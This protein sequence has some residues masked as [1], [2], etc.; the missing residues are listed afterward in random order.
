MEKVNDSHPIRI[1][2]KNE[3]AMIGPVQ[4]AARNYAGILGFKNK[5]CFHIE[6]LLEEIL[7]N[8][9]KFDFMPGQRE[10]INISFEKST[11]GM[12][13]TVHSLSVPLD[14]ERINS[15]RQT[16][17]GSILE[18][19]SSGLGSLIINSFADSVTYSNRGKL[20]QFI[21]IEKKLPYEAISDLDQ[22]P[23][24]ASAQQET[25]AD[26]KFYIRRLKPDEAY[27]ISQLAYYTY[28][29]SYIYD[30]V[31][32]PEYVRKLN[33]EGDMVSIVA[34][35][36]EN[37]DIIGHVAAVRH[38]QSGM[39]EMAVAFVNPRYRGGGCL[40]KGSEYLL[41]LLKSEGSAG[42]IAQAV[43]AHPFSQKAAFKLGLKETAFFISRVTPLEMN[44]LHEGHQIR[45]SFLLMYIA[46]RHDEEHEVFAPRQH[47][48]MV[49][50][51]YENVE[52]PVRLVTK[53]D[54]GQGLS[55]NTE[56][57]VSADSYKCGH[58]IVNQYSPG[59]KEEIAHALNTLCISR[60][61]TIYLYL[62]TNNPH[63]IIACEDAETLGFFFGGIMPSKRETEYILMEYLNNQKYEYD[64]VNVFSDFAKEL[65]A[66][67]RSH[68]PNEKV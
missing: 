47:A 22:A 28:S 16:D 24:V 2:I 41:A 54:P 50:R 59:A 45:D 64:S 60:T 43:T 66:Y 63:T 14:V 51:I 38:D 65:L 53:A 7:T 40:Q 20:G 31:Y 34:V 39:P 46:L 12:T 18:G 35:N 27:S 44:E 9:I 57:D 33:E 48:T 68:D 30:K 5:E 56:L 55:E 15:F 67:V 49:K 42:V 52:V 1:V 61:E 21:V 25:K 11:L 26:F 4:A 8:I 36:E 19:K 17:S 23:D 37:E 10:D 32:Y 29:I 58:I 13:I 6:L 62:P 3:V